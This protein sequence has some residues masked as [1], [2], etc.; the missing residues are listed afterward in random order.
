MSQAQDIS[1]QV[2]LFDYL[3]H[4]GYLDISESNLPINISCPTHIDNKP[5]M[6]LYSPKNRDGY[7][8][9]C[10]TSYNSFQMHRK[11]NDLDYYETVQYFLENFE[12]NLSNTA[13]KQREN[14]K[15]NTKIIEFSKKA[16]PLIRTLDLTERAIRFRELE[17]KIFEKSR[18][19]K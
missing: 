4:I 16:I 5:S 7:C 17:V 15:T 12:I 18:G 1:E 8:F 6:R 10:G 13:E 2:T 14:I 11:L 3:K 19:T 9:S